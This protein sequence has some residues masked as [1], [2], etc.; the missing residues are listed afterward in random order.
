[1]NSGGFSKSVI[2]LTAAIQGL[3]SLGIPLVMGWLSD[4][5]G[6]RWVLIASFADVSVSLLLLAFSRSMWQFCAFVV[7]FS[8][9]NVPQAVGPAYV[10]D[11][12]PAWN[13]G[14]GISLFQSKFCIGNIAG[15]A[16]TGY[17]IERLGIF[18]PILA[19]GLFPIAAT[20]LLL[21]LREKTR[22][23]QAPTAPR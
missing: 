4:S 20:V 18:T 14:R 16:A 3:V 15:M 9:L 7:L 17:A 13:V 10:V 12:N 19:S 11:I 6:R 22:P 8:F 23:S 21:F 5:I 2:T 1:M